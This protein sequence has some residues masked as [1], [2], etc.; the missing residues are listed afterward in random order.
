VKRSLARLR[1]L[2]GLGRAGPEQVQ[3][4]GTVPRLPLR[5]RYYG[6]REERR[7]VVVQDLG[8]LVELP[9]PAS[10][11]T[12]QVFTVGVLPLEEPPKRPGVV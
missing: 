9:P 5:L 6:G 3:A 4:A 2:L 7:G 8:R 11:L 10:G 1:R 12:G